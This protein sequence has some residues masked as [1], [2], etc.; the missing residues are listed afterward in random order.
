MPGLTCG[1]WREF[2]VGPRYVL[3][4]LSLGKE[5]GNLLASPFGPVA[6][7]DRATVS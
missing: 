7:M 4:R 5:L 1:F 6:Q 2:H 3:P